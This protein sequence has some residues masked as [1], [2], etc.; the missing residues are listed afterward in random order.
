MTLLYAKWGPNISRNLAISFRP[1][2]ASDTDYVRIV[3]DKSSNWPVCSASYGY[4]AGHIHRMNLRVDKHCYAA[5]VTVHEFLHIIGL[6]HEHQRPDR[7]D[8]VWI[9]FD[10]IQP[11]YH[12]AFN[13]CD[14]CKTYNVPYDPKSIMH[15]PAKAFCVDC[16]KLVIH[17][18]VIENHLFLN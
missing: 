16:D 1:K 14:D 6:M 4:T 7:D 12:S 17:S 5:T 8:Y 13:K 3:D 9:D 10:N 2:K 18:K 11:D 15:Y